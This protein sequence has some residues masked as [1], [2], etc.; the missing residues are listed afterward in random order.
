LSSHFSLTGL[1]ERL[2]FSEEVC[3]RTGAITLEGATAPAIARFTRRSCGPE[4]LTSA[5]ILGVSAERSSDQSQ[6]AQAV[7]M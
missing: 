6:L 5:G 7:F 1:F 2:L 4:R 3:C